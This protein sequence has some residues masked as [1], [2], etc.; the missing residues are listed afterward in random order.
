MK[1]F[2]FKLNF[3]LNL[4]KKNK[5]LKITNNFLENTKK[6][7]KLEN[8]K[9]LI[10]EKYYKFYTKNF[11]INYSL[12]FLS[13]IFFYYLIYLS[14]PGILH[15]KSDQNYFT[16]IL[17]E[18]YGLE[19]SL[20]PEISYSILPKPHFQ[21]NDVIIFNKQGEY[22]KEIAQVKKV[23]VYLNQKN[24]LKKQKLEINSVE[25]F[26]TN[27]FITKFDIEFI[28]DYLKKGFNNKPLVIKRANLFF[29]D[30]DKNTISFLNLRKINMN[31]N[32]RTSQDLLMSNGEIFNIP[33]NL[34]WKQ[35]QKKLE[36][37][38][39]LKFKKIKLNILNSTKLINEKRKNKLQIYLNRS[40]YLI[41]YDLDNNKVEF[42][43]D[44]SFIGNN[45][46]TFLGK[47]FLDPFNFDI[48]SS[49]DS[50]KINKLITNN[51]FLKEVL[52][53]EFILNENFN[54]TI[55]LDVKNLEKNPLF[56][57][58][59]INAN[60]IGEAIDFSNSVFLNEK[61]ANLIF[62][63]AILYEEKNNLIFKGDLEFIIN[64]LN[65]LFNKFVVPKK[66]RNKLNKLKFEI[67]IN[68][69]KSDFKILNI[70]NDNFK[71]KE[72]KE[73]DDLIYEFNSGGIK[74]S[75]WIEFK[76]FTNKIISSYSG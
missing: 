52:S 19:F 50:L 59:N 58:L 60:F 25:L 2:K 49:L 10:L 55:N 4:S 74:I 1:N 11:K 62:K 18:Q 6:L 75:N 69:T 71:D 32:D 51:L 76:M 9:K 13:I 38:T 7:I 43:S 70:I 57:S 17:K 45:K 66:N 36:Q 14:F 23:K 12:F 39:N 44:N 73:I 31:Y 15:N 5:I 41:N 63:K 3:L 67:I 42:K 56:E 54:G 26:E 34:V 64:D 48:S 68:L 16:K 65:K 33:F 46:I 29:Q 21:I 40:R 47:I 72:L 37:N 20:T 30:Q 53:S 22:Q 24:F 61:I 28:K 8:T 35:D 27:F